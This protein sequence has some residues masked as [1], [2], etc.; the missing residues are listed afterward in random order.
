[1]YELILGNLKTSNERLWFSTCCR[2]AKI[3]L[4]DRNFSQMEPLL[5]EMKKTCKLPGMENDA[6]YVSFDKQKGNFLLELFSL[7]I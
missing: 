4:D 3:Y 1:M 2:L 7:E 5:G 6:S